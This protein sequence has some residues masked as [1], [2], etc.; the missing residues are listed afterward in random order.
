MK[1]IKIGFDLDGVLVNKPP[2]IP[3]RLL[4]WLV[5]SHT[6]RN[7]YYRYPTLRLERLIRWLAHHPFLRPAIKKNLRFIQK[8]A[9]EK[10][11]RL[12]LITSRYSFLEKRTW[13]WL[14]NHQLDRIFEKVLI[15]LKNE[16]PHLFKKRKIK[17]LKIDIFIDDD[18]PL[19]SYLAKELPQTKIFC[20]NHHRK[21]QS[22]LLL[23]QSLEEIFLK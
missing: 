1:K 3:K 22:S 20:F 4:E 14:K 23:I 12:F 10:K 8:L 19:A 9:K 2:L 16:Q 6:H 5:R 11:Y 18:F 17:D 15:N 21:K 13:Q 7:L